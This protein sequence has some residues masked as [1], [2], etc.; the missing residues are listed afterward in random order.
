MTV[1][2]DDVR[3]IAQLA[4]LDL[5]PERAVALARELEAILEHVRVLAALDTAGVQAVEGVGAAGM[6]LRADAGPPLALRRSPDAFA[7][8]WHDGFFVVPRLPTHETT[9]EA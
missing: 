3:Y 1:T 8:E 9:G 7:P 2:L 5:T 6:P 4:R